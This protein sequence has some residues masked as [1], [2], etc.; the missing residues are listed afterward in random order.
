M[1]RTTIRTRTF[2]AI[3]IAM[4]ASCAIE[5]DHDDVATAVDAALFEGHSTVDPCKSEQPP[6]GYAL[7]RGTEGDDTIDLVGKPGNHFVVAGP[8]NDTI[9]AGP[10]KDIVCAGPGEDVVHGQGGRDYID[11]GYGNDELH[12]DDGDDLVH[13]RAGSDTIFGGPDDDVLFGDLLDDRM[14]GGHGQDLLVGGHGTDFMHGEEGNDWLRGD[15]NGDQFV[16]GAGED[17]ASFATTTPPGQAGFGP[18]PPN[19]IDADLALGAGQSCKGKNPENLDEEIEYPGCSWGDGRDGLMGVEI[20]IG[21]HFDD[22]LIG[23]AGR[24]VF[25]GGYGNDAFAEMEATDEMHGGPGSDGCNGVPCDD[26]GEPPAALPIVFVDGHPADAGLVFLGSSAG[27]NVTLEVNGGGFRVTEHGG[28]A[29]AAGAHCVH[30]DPA[31]KNVVDCTVAEPLRWALLWG[32]AGDDVLRVGEGLP[33]DFTPTVDGG[34]GDDV[35]Q[36]ASGPD[37]LFA[38]ESGHDELYGHAGDDALISESHDGDLLA[39][40]DGNDQ[41]VSNFPCAGH[42][43][44]GGDGQDIAGF[45]RVGTSHRVMAQLGG[46]TASPSNFHGRALSPGTCGNDPASWT[47]LEPGLEILEGGSLNDVLYGDDGPNTIWARDGDDEVRGFGGDDVLVG[48][49]GNDHVYGGPGRDILRGGGGYD[50]LYAKDGQADRVLSCGA[51]G[52][53]VASADPHDPPAQGC[54]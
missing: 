38:G 1:K 33:R 9:L 47:I 17:V 50:W 12:G 8:G 32:D 23:G 6:D 27:E 2:S 46:A 29:L 51:H 18:S 31:A 35:L 42:L 53:R 28:I 30:P 7:V 40:G 14:F 20:V 41:L 49:T 54:N 44:R 11:G 5:P 13:G 19:G 52:G 21:S 3:A 37:I 25:W 45:A 39:A 4:L 24:N 10:G 15:T 36:G 22:V 43:Y 34:P 16:G 26:A 48:N